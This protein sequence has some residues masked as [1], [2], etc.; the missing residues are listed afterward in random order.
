MELPEPIKKWQQKQ[1]QKRYGSAFEGTPENIADWEKDLE[2]YEKKIDIDIKETDQQS[3]LYRKVGESY[4]KMEMFDK[5]ILYLNK[6]IE[7][8]YN[9]PDVFYSLG[10]CQGLRASKHNWDPDYTRKAEETFLK[11]LNLKDNYESAKFQL[12][13]IYFYGYGLVNKYRI[14]SATINISL[15]E[16]RQKG[17][18]LM[19]EYQFKD[20]DNI[21]SYFALG[22]MYNILGQVEKSAEQYTKAA[23]ITMGKYPD[24]YTASPEY[25]KA[26]ENLSLIQKGK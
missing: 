12:G 25:Q 19:T 8:G 9:D 3:K 24:T 10:I 2:K 22:G 18:E 11:V 1:M 5:C 15:Q 6:A 4:G 20:P 26:M 13:L 16:F 21:Q 7:T 14:K 17:I 23:Q